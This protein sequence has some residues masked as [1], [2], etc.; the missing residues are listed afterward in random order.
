VS[1]GVGGLY[2]SYYARLAA[3]ASVAVAIV[4]AYACAAIAAALRA[5]WRRTGTLRAHAG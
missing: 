3:G 4:A 1:S 5:P 2:L